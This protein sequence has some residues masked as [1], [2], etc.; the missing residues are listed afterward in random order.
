M[1]LAFGSQPAASDEEPRSST[2]QNASEI[3]RHDRDLLEEPDSSASS[4]SGSESGAVEISAT[5]RMISATWGSILTTL[6]GRSDD[7]AWTSAR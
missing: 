6:L 2:S 7:R 4:M 3:R 1:S 5:Q